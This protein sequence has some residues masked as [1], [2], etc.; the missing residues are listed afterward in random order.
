MFPVANGA[1]PGCH[2]SAH[3]PQR[4]SELNLTPKEVA[5]LADP[6]WATE[7]EADLIHMLRRQEGSPV[8]QVL[9]E[10]GDSLD[11]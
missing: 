4:S 10:Y 7:D 1:P 9:A 2:P 8:E 5:L 6:E 11:G 3:A